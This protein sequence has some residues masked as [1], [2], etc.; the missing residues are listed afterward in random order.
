MCPSGVLEPQQLEQDMQ[1]SWRAVS[2]CALASRRRSGMPRP[3]ARRL[4]AS[5]ALFTPA[6]ASARLA[7][8][9][10]NLERYCKLS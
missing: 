5:A 7:A 9:V 2:A 6:A 4:I 3:S 8:T 1:G 10:S